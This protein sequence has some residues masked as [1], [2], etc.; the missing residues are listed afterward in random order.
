MTSASEKNGD[1]SIVFSVQG[2]SGSP[3]GPDPEN[4]VGELKTLEA[5]VG[6][7]LLGCKCPVRRGIV[8]REQDSLD[9]LQHVQIIMNDGPN[10]LA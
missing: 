1:L 4:S 2:T 10:P 7:F 3:T 9:D 8:V 6:Q 5:R